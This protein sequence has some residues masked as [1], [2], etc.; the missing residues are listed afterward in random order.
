MSL[1]LMS[2]A[3]NAGAATAAPAP[4]LALSGISK[5]YPGVVA[6]NGIDLAIE[7]GT[8]HAVVGE[9]GA[10]KS[11]LIKIVTGVIQ[12]D[13][14][15]MRLKNE[16]ISIPDPR[17]ANRLGIVAVP[18]DVLLVPEFLVGRNILLGMEK[19]VTRREGLD[20][21]ETKVV[22]AALTQVGA[23]FDPHTPTRSLSVPQ[24]RLA[25]IARA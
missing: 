25:H 20:T 7:P 24:L 10:G 16:L 23:N 4:L 1:N 11:T 6:L 13:A 9:N 12:A 14:G 15:E 22:A 8:I 2:A 19:A 5:S 17:E 21:E 3:N 18:Q